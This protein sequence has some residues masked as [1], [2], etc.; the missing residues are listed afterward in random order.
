VAAKALPDFGPGDNLQLKLV[1][2]ALLGSCPKAA[3]QVGESI[4]FVFCRCRL[5]PSGGPQSCLR[6]FTISHIPA[7]HAH[8]AGVCAG[9]RS[10]RTGGGWRSSRASASPGGTALG[11]RP[12]PS[13][14][15]SAPPAASSAR[16]PCAP[17]CSR[18]HILCY[19]RPNLM[20]VA[21][22]LGCASRRYSPNIQEIVVLDSK[23]VRRAKLYYLRER[24][25]KEYRVSTKT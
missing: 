22:D 5:Q 4:P 3:R 8:G 18:C 6:T 16:S 10:P 24:Q 21:T 9:S 19:G 23:R 11:G 12:S 17:L 20:L 1:C 13:A 7:G 25:P 2:N 15:T 14:T